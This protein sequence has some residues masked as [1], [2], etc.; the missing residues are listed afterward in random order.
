MPH[1]SLPTLATL[2]FLLCF[3]VGPH[4]LAG[5][6]PENVL[7]VVNQNSESSLT[8]ANYYIRLR[9]IP[10]QNVLY[11]DWQ[12][13]L[14]KT[15]GKAFKDKILEPI[16]KTID[17][18]KLSA[19]IDYVV[20]SAGFPW[21]VDCQ[22]LFPD[23]KFPRQMRPVASINGATYLWQY[24]MRS[25]PA[26]MGLT[27]N[28]YVPGNS[29]KNVSR[30]TQ[31]ATVTSQGFRTRYSWQRGGKK[32]ADHKQGQRYLLSCVLG[33]TEGRGNSIE[34]IARYLVASRAADG[35]R[36]AG[37]FYYMQNG[38]VRSKTRHDCFESVAGLLRKEGANVVVK[39]GKLPT[40]A[41][42]IMGLTLGTAKFDLPGAKLRILPG[43][44]CEHLTSFGGDLRA[45]AGQ[46]PLTVFLRA[47]SA[48]ASG[49]VTEPF[50]IQ[51]KFPLPTIHLHYRRGCSLAEAFYQSV[52]GPYQLLIVGD[53]L[54]QPWAVPPRCKAAGLGAGK[55]VT[56]EL[57]VQP[58]LGKDVGRCEVYI[59][60]VLRAHAP[61]E[62]PLKLDTTKLTEGY[63]ELR[64]VAVKNNPIETRGRLVTG[65]NV[66]NAP[67]EDLTLSSKPGQRVGRTS[68]VTLAVSGG[69][70]ER[71]MI[72]QNS[73]SLGLAKGPGLELRIS[74]SR[75]GRGPCRLHAVDP[76]TGERSAPIWLWV[77]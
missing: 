42:D 63:H 64:L 16:L 65:V 26:L 35:K 8:A 30:C 59:D 75:L 71:V 11:L 24:V 34:E 37:T 39:K 21:A 10:P 44:I 13:S 2:L 49:T 67:G 3:A 58:L 25:S 47:G 17:G 66:N 69:D 5:G 43:A 45:K 20:Y 40:G 70:R 74:A 38:D 18:R 53:P 73:R 32:S 52:S 28:S 31:L 72:R 14:S 48:G 29:L 36:P 12:G 27:T 76:V 51:A 9:D 57:V 55:V 4:C 56:G 19:Q 68:T 15:D 6:G 54:C 77:E 7:L 22:N 23:E 61:M 33:V 41:R 50:A 62:G 1:R 46:T 60:G